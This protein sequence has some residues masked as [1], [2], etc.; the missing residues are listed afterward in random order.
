MFSVIFPG[1]GSQTVGMAANLY[2]EYSYI[3]ELFDKA[4]DIL[5]VPLSKIILTG[6]KEKLNETENT[7]PAIFLVSY[8]IY[9]VI[10]K[11]TD[12]DLSKA[13]YFAGHS[14]GEYSALSASGSIDFNS[15]LKLLQKRGRS[16]Q[17]AVPKGEGGMLAILGEKIENIKEIFINNKDAFECYIANDNSNGQIVV[18]GKNK[19][20]ES[21]I[22][23]LKKKS[24]KNIKLPVSAPFHC[25]LMSPA[26]EIMQNEIFNT[27]F[28]DSNNSIIS[29]VT[30]KEMQKSG[31]IKDL[32]VKQIESPVRWRES[33]IYMINNNVKNFVEIGP[34]KILS[35]M[36]KRIDR[37]V[38]IVSVNEL[39]DIKNISFND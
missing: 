23:E 34:G 9:E 1:Q 22:I 17:S 5:G 30:S 18:S 32:L 16:M 20:L 21:L 19:D 12:I 39:D 37:N 10:K 38:N 26:T 8:S 4:D 7:Q 13:K 27:K 6:P 14:L 24:I 36:I 33:I 35:G 29:N 11:E 25:K 28:K 2:K 15:T 31:D 3:K